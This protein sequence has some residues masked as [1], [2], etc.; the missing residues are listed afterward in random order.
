MKTPSASFPPT[1]HCWLWWSRLSIS[2]MYLFRPIEYENMRISQIWST[3]FVQSDWIWEYEDF[4]IMVNCICSDRLNM[5]IWGFL[6]YGQLY[7]FRPIECISDSDAVFHLYFYFIFCFWIQKLHQDWKTR[8]SGKVLA[9]RMAP[10][11]CISYFFF[12]ILELHQ[13]WDLYSKF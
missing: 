3:V 4:S 7:L 8:H 5:R 6:K 12:S 1:L 11:V 2:Q 9:E 13:F 10:C